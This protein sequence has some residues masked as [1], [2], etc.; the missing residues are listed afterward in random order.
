M[1]IVYVFKTDVQDKQSARHIILFLQRVF[2]RCRINF[3][4]DD[5]D[6]ILRI[7]SSQGLIEDAQI[8]LLATRQGY[9]CEP[10]VD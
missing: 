7:E 5:C 10:L 9:Y 2:S 8:Q 4:L 6:R 1:N 3:D